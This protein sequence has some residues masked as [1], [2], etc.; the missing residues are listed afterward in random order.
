MDH[1]KLLCDISELNNLFRDSISVENFMQRTVE[2][3]AH[4]MQADV[5]SVYLYEEDR[6]LI[7]LKA[8]F[9]LNP[10]SVGKVS[11]RLGEG[12]TGLAL[13][14]LKPVCVSNAS[15]HPNYRFF[16]ETDEEPFENFLAVPITRG[17]TRIGVLVLQRKKR[18]K[19]SGADA[20]ACKAV[21]SQLAN[22][23]EN[24]KFLL[25]LHAPVEEKSLHAAA[26]ELALVKGQVASEGFAFAPALVVDRLKTFRS[27][28]SR[29][30]EGP[31]TLE[32]FDNA[33]ALTS[34][35]LSDLQSEVEEKLTDAASLIFASHLMIL[36]DKEFVGAM[37]KL[38]E[39]SIPVPTAVLRVAQQYI[40]IFEASPAPNMREKVQD[41]EDLVVRLM[42]NL[43]GESESQADYRN[44][45]VIAKEIFPSDLLRMSSEDVRAIVVATGGATSH[46]SIL[47]RSLGI[48][49]VIA[50][51]PELMNISP[52]TMLLI[53]AETGNIYVDP[54]DEVIAEFEARNK[55]RTQVQIER[56]TAKPQTFTADG[57]RVMLRANI[58]LLSDLKLAK[59]VHCDGV[60]LYRTE[61]PFII[62]SNFPSEQEQYVIYRRLVEGMESKPVVF[63]TLDIGGDK[64]LSYLQNAKEQNPSLGMRSIRF[65]LQN[66]DV[67]SQQIRAI[68]R[69]G[70]GEDLRIMFPMI[71][72]VEEFLQAKDILLRCS[73]KLTDEKIEHNHNPKIG[74]MVELPAGVHLSEDFAVV[75]DFF[76]IGTN[77]FV[78]FMLAVDRTNENVA[79]FYLP[80]HPSVVRALKTIVDGAE[81]HGREV[82]VCGDISHQQPFIPLLLGLGIRTLSLEP[83]YIPKTQQ[84]IAKITLPEAQK[85]AAEVLAQSSAQKTAELLGIAANSR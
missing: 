15:S 10:D 65:S 80:H 28:L 85:L 35:Q 77:D 79:G 69:A 40:G 45:I 26:V 46:L 8:T 16:P 31:H 71:S 38:I 23:I 36:K 73:R 32:D 60:G 55:A 11:M 67:F 83:Q 33:V 59:E 58:N 62:R 44:K 30:F 22:I 81:K 29:H 70:L 68:L 17:T 52:G 3:V 21:A 37:R 41:L 57:T 53:D 82:S 61:F 66:I 48:P 19:F 39:E 54:S 56:I 49:M 63:R 24:A 34:E 72:A 9:G 4:H 2:M 42:F 18:R 51:R 25:T 1:V 6:D 5:C 50:N 14:D 47:A 64:I 20:M 7:V 13:K 74:M 75:A 27:L 43:F 78:Q 12:L 76:S 84:T